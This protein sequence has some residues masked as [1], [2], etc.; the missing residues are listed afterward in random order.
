MALAVYM[1]IL[2]AEATHSSTTPKHLRH[3][4]FWPRVGASIIH[5]KKSDANFTRFVTTFHLLRPSWDIK[6]VF[7]SLQV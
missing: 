2:V 3:I 7:Y 4:M 1:T 6:L 5:T